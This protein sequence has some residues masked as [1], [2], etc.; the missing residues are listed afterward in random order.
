MPCCLISALMGLPR[1]ALVWLL[2]FTNYLGEAFSIAGKPHFLIFVGLLF[3]PWTTLA[4]AWSIQ[5]SGGHLDLGHWIL[6]VF[7]LISDLGS[8]KKTATKR[9]SY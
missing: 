7:A 3:L 4:F 1:L 2:I 5:S 6:L 8:S 9:E